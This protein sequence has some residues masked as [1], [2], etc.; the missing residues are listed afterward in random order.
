MYRGSCS[1][2]IC[3]KQFKTADI[4]ASVESELDLLAPCSD[5][6]PPVLENEVRSI[7][8]TTLSPR[9]FHLQC[10][11]EL[12]SFEHGV[13]LCPFAERVYPEPRGNMLGPRGSWQPTKAAQLVIET[14]KAVQVY[15]NSQAPS[16]AIPR[17]KI[18]SIVSL[19]GYNYQL[20]A[21]PDGTLFQVKEAFDL[22]SLVASQ[23]IPPNLQGSLMSNRP[24][25][26]FLREKNSLKALEQA[27][28]T[29]NRTAPTQTQASSFSLRQ[30][31]VERQSRQKYTKWMDDQG[32]GLQGTDSYYSK[33]QA[34]KKEKDHSI[35]LKLGHWDPGFELSRWLPSSLNEAERKAAL[36]R[37]RY[38]IFS[39]MSLEDI[40]EEGPVLGVVAEEDMGEEIGEEAYEDDEGAEASEIEDE[41]A[42]ATSGEKATSDEKTTSGNAEEEAAKV[43]VTG[44]P[45]ENQP[46]REEMSLT[47]KG[48]NMVKGDKKRKESSEKDSE[49]N[50]KGSPRVMK[51]RKE[52]NEEQSEEKCET[53]DQKK[54]GT[55]SEDDF[56]SHDEAKAASNLEKEKDVADLKDHEEE[57][58]VSNPAE[59]NGESDLKDHKQEQAASRLEKEK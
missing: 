57:Q 36:R 5:H 23:D 47:Q 17:G 50:D 26:A 28:N 42:A 33:D 16:P 55:K 27:I 52:K 49:K 12:L 48:R 8:L 21:G 3:R 4:R 40:G 22:Y 53:D 24:L 15:I 18:P 25:H 19:E 46:K 32:L 59:E 20:R 37:E 43:S 34:S 35:A 1:S 6:K 29:G 51:R 39:G 11:H 9:L 54:A 56:K 30:Q 41:E 44:S 10:L 45:D 13:G 31:D 38:G 7:G 14:W 58:E 2:Y